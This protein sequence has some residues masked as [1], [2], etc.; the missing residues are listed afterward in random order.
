M[1]L[2]ID[3]KIFARDRVGMVLVVTLGEGE[4]FSSSWRETFIKTLI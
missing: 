1:A 2:V 3:G 4:R